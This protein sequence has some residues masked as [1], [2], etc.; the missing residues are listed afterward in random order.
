MRNRPPQ[1]LY[2]FAFL[3]HWSNWLDEAGIQAPGPASRSSR[4]PEGRHHSC[5]PRPPRCSATGQL[6]NGRIHL[7]E[8]RTFPRPIHMCQKHRCRPKQ[9]PATA[10]QAKSSLGR[11]SSLLQYRPLSHTLHCNC[12]SALPSSGTP[13]V[14]SCLTFCG[15][16]LKGHKRIGSLKNR[17]HLWFLLNRGAGQAG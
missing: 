16:G 9:G 15:D 1:R 7:G 2:I 11:L 4:Y 10:G 5:Q 6:H 13:A 3:T 17:H 8:A 12:D 14:M